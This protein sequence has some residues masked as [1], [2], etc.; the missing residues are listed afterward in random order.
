VLAGGG[1]RPP[2]WR[3]AVY[4]EDRTRGWRMLRTERY[5]YVEWH[6][7]EEELY[8]MNSDPYQLR[9][10]HADRDKAVIMSQLSRRLSA[11]KSCSGDSCR[12][13]EVAP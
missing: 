5:A 2:G 8:D 4:V 12:S 7:G 13:A 10:L 9:S 3:D 11:M 1:A 6:T